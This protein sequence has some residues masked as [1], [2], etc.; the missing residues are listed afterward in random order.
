MSRFRVVA[1][2]VITT[3]VVIA[4]WLGVGQFRAEEQASLPMAQVR[5]GEFVAVI[6]A[7]GQIQADRSVPIYAPLVQDLRIAWM[8]PVS[9]RV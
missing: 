2:I 3:S 1:A 8:A 9:E 6:R 7:R 4:V 5:S